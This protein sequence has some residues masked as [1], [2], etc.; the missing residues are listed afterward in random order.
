MRP[1]TTLCAALVALALTRPA[2]AQPPA[3]LPLDELLSRHLAARGGA[4]RLAALHSLRLAG[5]LIEGDGGGRVELRWQWTVAR[6]GRLREE[7]TQQGLTAVKGW[8]GA[9]GWRF[10]PFEGRREAE[11]LPADEVKSLARDAD[12][13]GPLLG[14]KEKGLKAEYLG[15]Q[16]VDGT[17]AHE[18]RVTF[19]DG[20]VEEHYLDAEHYLASL[21]A[22]L[23]ASAGD[24]ALATATN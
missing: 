10:S 11:R 18:V 15:V 20:D 17:P 19:P 6:P 2:A 8:D 22:E 4:A 3:P 7:L 1:A 21:P 23:L 5:K 13:D 14:W 24:T 9:V 12:L 16:D